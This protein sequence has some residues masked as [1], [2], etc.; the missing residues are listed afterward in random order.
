MFA[1]LQSKQSAT[2]MFMLNIQTRKT[3][4]VLIQL[5]LSVQ[6]HVLLILGH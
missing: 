1:E 2:V 5:L 6:G 3:I 4:Q